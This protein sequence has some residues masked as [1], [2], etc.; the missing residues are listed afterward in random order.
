MPMEWATDENG[1]WQLINTD[2]IIPDPSTTPNVFPIDYV[3]PTVTLATGEVNLIRDAW[4]NS[5]PGE[6]TLIGNN[7]YVDPLLPMPPPAV[8]PVTYEGL[9][10][11]FQ[12][13]LNDFKNIPTNVG[14]TLG[15][16]SLTN[17]TFLGFTGVTAFIIMYMLMKNRNS[18]KTL[19]PILMLKGGT[20]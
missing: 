10:G 5:I 1:D 19:L 3:P 12:G 8:P 17:F 16:M 9:G 11:L 6:V 14:T 18:M 13:I 20:T 4:G 7:T 15:N 2:P